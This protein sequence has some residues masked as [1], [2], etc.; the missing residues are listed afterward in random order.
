MLTPLAPPNAEL[1]NA[2]RIPHPSMVSSRLLQPMSA[3]RG[4]SEGAR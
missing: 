2:G 4:T 1:A 3:P